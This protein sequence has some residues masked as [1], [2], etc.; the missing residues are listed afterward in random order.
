MR[1]ADS[2]TSITGIRH[3]AAPAQ[4]DWSAKAMSNDSHQDH[5]SREKILM[6]LS[7]D[8]VASVSTA[9]TTTH[10]VEGEEY[11]D[12]EHLD[13]GVR[14]SVGTPGTMSHLLLRRSVHADTWKKVLEQV[15]TLHI[16]KSHARA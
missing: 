7:D 1:E 16:T 4:R 3:A 13:Q 8:E 15:T 9:E 2:T 12:L 14:S 5:T 11:I 6:L 10:P